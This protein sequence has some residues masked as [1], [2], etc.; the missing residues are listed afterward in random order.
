MQRL[1]CGEIQALLRRGAQLVDVRTAAEFRSGA[2]PGS[3]NLPVQAIG[4]APRVLDP[5]RPVLVYCRS[6]N[7]SA[8]AKTWLEA[9]GFGEVLDLG[10]PYFFAECL[11]AEPEPAVAPAFA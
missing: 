10:A 4:H 11:P 1:P 2:L 7:R 6:G 3:V 5:S 9:M 8:F